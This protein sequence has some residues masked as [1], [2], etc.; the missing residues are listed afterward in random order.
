MDVPTTQYPAKILLFG[1]Y[2]IIH[3]SDALV[4]PYHKLFGRW[5]VSHAQPLPQKDLSDFLNYVSS[6]SGCNLSKVKRIKDEK[7]SFDSTIPTGYGIG[8]SGALSAAIYELVFDRDKNL[9][10]T[11]DKLAEIESFFH[12]SSSGMDPLASHLRK[13][14][15]IC[16]GEVLA[17]SEFKSPTDIYIYDSHIIRK[18]K[19]LIEYYK[20]MREAD[21]SFLATSKALA[22]FNARIIREI[23]NT[24]NYTSSFK[25]ISH[26]QFHHFDKMIPTEVKSI[27]Q[28]GLE[29]DTYYFKLCGAG[30]GGFFL[31]HS[32]DKQVIDG[33][34][35]I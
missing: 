11:K 29:S 19:P 25:E 34:D 32:N 18:S 24:Q 7:W 4:L 31:V 28:K 15:H 23:I 30:G 6:L 3:G 27:W 33:L 10:E 35:S 9:I 14:I 16:D 20:M 1:E 5:Q 17:L 2:S 13:P 22:K 8:S 26:I 21:L 12:G